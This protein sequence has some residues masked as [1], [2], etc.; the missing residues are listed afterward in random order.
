MSVEEY[1]IYKKKKTVI[2]MK[3]DIP[4]EKKKKQ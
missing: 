4:E 3:R 2:S 1:Q